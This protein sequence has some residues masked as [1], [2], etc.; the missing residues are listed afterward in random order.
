MYPHRCVIQKNTNFKHFQTNWF[1]SH[2]K[3]SEM[4]LSNM[5]IYIAKKQIHYNVHTNN[6]GQG[7]DSTTLEREGERYY[8]SLFTPFLALIAQRVLNNAT[9]KAQDSLIEI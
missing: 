6:R 3:R 2:A 8:S 5:Y 7:R 1:Q 9:T 4:Y